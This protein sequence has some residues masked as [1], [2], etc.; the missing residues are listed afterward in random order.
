M[1]YTVEKARI[2]ISVLKYV[3]EGSKS[4]IPSK[5]RQDHSL[6]QIHL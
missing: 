4:I 6:K 1:A 3:K 2:Y 5:L